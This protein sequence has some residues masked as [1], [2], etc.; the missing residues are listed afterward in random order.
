MLEPTISSVTLIMV[1]S[2][3]ACV[4]SQL[5]RSALAPA[6]LCRPDAQFPVRASDRPPARVTSSGD[7]SRRLTIGSKF[8]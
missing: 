1:M 3:E 5:C 4:A 2:A 7:G 6:G 8:I